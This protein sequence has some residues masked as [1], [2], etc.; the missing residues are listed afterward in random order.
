MFMPQGPWGQKQ[1]EIA[2]EKLFE[3]WRVPIENPPAKP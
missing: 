3:K 2:H 1:I